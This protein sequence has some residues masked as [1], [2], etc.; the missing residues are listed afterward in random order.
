MDLKIDDVATM[1]NVPEATIRHWVVEGQLPAYRIE[2]EWRFNRMEVEDSIMTNKIPAGVGETASGA[3]GSLQFSLYRALHKG[4]ILSFIQGNNKE[5]VIRASVAAIANELRVDGN[6]LSEQLLSRE[7]LQSTG[8]GSGI[9]IPHTRDFLLNSHQ[10][11]VVV[12]LL[13]KPIPYD[14]LDGQPVSILFFLFASSDKRHL[15]LL[16]KLAHLAN[17]SEARSFLAS[18]PTKEQLLNFVR[19][20]EGQVQNCSLNS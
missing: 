12:T 8:V 14:A 17:S 20:W 16:A 1:L 6:I 7:K 11:S 2:N 13:D 19:Q 10:D 15:H 9:A 3:I 18:K 4:A 5:E